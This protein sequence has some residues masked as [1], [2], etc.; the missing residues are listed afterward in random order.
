MA[1]KKYLSLVSGVVNSIAAIATSAGAG[2]ADKIVQT[3]ADGKLDISLMPSGLGGATTTAVASEVLT[4]GDFV[5]IYDD[6][7]TVKCRKA[8]ATDATKQ[9]DGY[10]RAGFANGATATVYLDGVNANVAGLTVGTSY[11]LSTS[12]DGSFTATAPST[13]GNVVQ[14]LGVAIDTGKILFD[15]GNVVVVIG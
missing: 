10:V 8:N 9:A 7:G 1:I 2:D 5:N 11:Y 4:A 14:K 12:V 13:S 15:R 6:A 3:S